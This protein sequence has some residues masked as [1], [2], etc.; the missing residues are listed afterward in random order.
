MR[1]EPPARQRGP[2]LQQR[3]APLQRPEPPSRQSPIRSPMPP[4]TRPARPISRQ[5]SSHDPRRLLFLG[6][7]HPATGAPAPCFPAMAAKLRSGPR[8]VRFMT[9]H[10]PPFGGR[11]PDHRAAFPRPRR[12]SGQADDRDY[13]ATRLPPRRARMPRERAARS[14]PF[15]RFRAIT[16]TIPF[17]IAR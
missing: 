11:N 12:Y 2:K 13:P 16:M 17:S 5:S 8:P 1:P 15:S 14:L 10:A 3:P 9:A 6:W 7:R 4:T